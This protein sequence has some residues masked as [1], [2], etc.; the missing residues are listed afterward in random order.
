M[1]N[2]GSPPLENARELEK[3]KEWREYTSKLCSGRPAKNWEDE[4][5]VSGGTSF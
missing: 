3:A 4:D 1:G 2:I 5:K